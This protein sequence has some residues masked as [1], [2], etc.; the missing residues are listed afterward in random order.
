MRDLGAVVSDDQRAADAEIQARKAQAAAQEASEYANHFATVL[1]SI[2]T[3]AKDEFTASKAT[4]ALEWRAGTDAKDEL[5]K[6]LA[7][8]AAVAAAPSLN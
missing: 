2:S 5:E 7:A 1:R 8:Q 6:A 3:T 4:R